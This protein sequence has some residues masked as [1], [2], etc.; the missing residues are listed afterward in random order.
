[1]KILYVL[2]HPNP[3]SFNGHLAEEAV[4]HLAS[5]HEVKF[6]D[7][8]QENFNS[9]ASL[10]DF[11]LP[12]HAKD[13]AFFLM[14]QAAFNEQRLSP[15]I[16]KALEQV[17]WADHLIFQF[18]LWWFATP[19]ILKGWFDRILVKGFAYDA[20]K[21]FDDGLLK[22][23][24]ASIVTSTQSP[25]T[26]YQTDGVHGAT[27]DTFLHPIHHTLRFVGM[28]ISSPFVTYGAFNLTLE[29]Q[30]NIIKNYKNYLDHLFK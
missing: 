30:K 23:K 27:L 10:Q 5:S 1:M 20:N 28:Q 8:Y 29:Q 25:A 13:E 26:A 9:V 6:S 15:D 12:T 18:P 11:N 22:G 2:A 17:Q 4:T 24:K 21:I 16:T 3:K 14:Q 7:L 19:A